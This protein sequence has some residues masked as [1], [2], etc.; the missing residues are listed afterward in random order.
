MFAGLSGGKTGRR[1]K[2]ANY[3]GMLYCIPEVIK[4]AASKIAITIDDKTLNRLDI[5]VKAKF[6]PN[7][8]KAIQ[9]A[10]IH[11]HR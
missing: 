10:G 8:S 7:R 1:Y 2:L 3:Y 11:D 4:M 9:E 6:F 5:L